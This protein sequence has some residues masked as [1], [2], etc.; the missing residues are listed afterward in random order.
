MTPQKVLDLLNDNPEVTGFC[1]AMSDACNEEKQ[2]GMKWVKCS[3]HLPGYA[4]ELHEIHGNHIIRRL[5]NKEVIKEYFILY[6]KQWGLEN[7]EWLDESV[8]ETNGWGDKC[9][10]CEHSPVSYSKQEISIGDKNG[11]HRSIFYNY[12]DECGA[13]SYVDWYD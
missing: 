8:D 4:K 5:D 9:P 12:C 1:R 13:S 6:G 11:T 10:H 2:K 7:F 3:E